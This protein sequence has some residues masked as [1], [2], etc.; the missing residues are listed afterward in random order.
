MKNVAV[1]ILAAGDS[2][3]FWPCGDKQLFRFAGSPLIRRLL[4]QLI[5]F[6]FE[7]FHIVVNKDN[8][9]AI[10]QIISQFKKQNIN[11]IVQKRG[12][13]MGTAILSAGELIKNKELLIINPNDVFENVLLHKWQQIYQ[14]KPE[15]IIA[16]MH[17]KGYFPGGYLTVSGSKIFSITEKPPKDNL[18]SDIVKFVF[19]YFRNSDNFLSVLKET[20]SNKDDRYEKAVQ[21]LVIKGAGFVFLEYRGFWSGLKYPWQIL[22]ITGFL[23]DG[24]K[25]NKG[26][27]VQIDK[28]A[29]IC[30]DVYIEDEVRVMEGAKIV[31]PAFI[32]RG[33]VIGNQAIIRES[34]IGENCVIGYC[35]EIARSYIGNSCWFHTNYIGDS[36]ISENVSMGAGTVLA[37]FKL[38]E[39]N[40]FSEINKDRV[41][42]GRLKLGAMVGKGVRIGINCSIMPGVKIGKNSLIGAAV[43]LRK[44]ISDDKKISQ[45]PVEYTITENKRLSSE[46]FR[47]QTIK[48]I[49]MF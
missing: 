2:T 48:K 47:N 46:N 18:P 32:G 37:N 27:N 23:L 4:S 10:E 24:I 40:I 29:V 38:N 16:G 17:L 8:R 44:D 5:S 42:T 28:S 33:T 45:K 34:M 20:T 13:G 43:L 26:R 21:K 19:D 3:R 7:N 41:D 36:V 1:L 49:K 9:Q 31:G 6:G 12:D 39:N 15:G 35:T 22:D 30:G 11:L 14:T 25:S